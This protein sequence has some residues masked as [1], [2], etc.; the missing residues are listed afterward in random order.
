MIPLRDNIPNVH[1]PVMVTTLVIINAAVFLCGRF[2][3]PQGQVYVF[4]IFGVVPLRITDTAWAMAHGYPQGW[5]VPFFTHMFL[6]SSWMH[7]IGN[8]WTLWIFGDNIEDVM[9]PFRF[10]L[11]YL[12]CGFAAL[13]AHLLFNFSS[14]I[15]VVGASG[16]IAGVMG[17]YLILYP[18]AKVVTLIPIFIF[19]W[20][21]D[22]P[23][24]LFLGVWFVLQFFNGAATA[25]GGGVAWWAHVGGFVAG[26]VLLKV[27]ENPKR[28]QECYLAG[29]N[30]FPFWKD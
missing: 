19:P 17:A 10:L 2:L 21:V 7:I 11:F 23:A 5:L 20:F 14:P 1:K 25:G 18:Y 4:H 24:V 26:I 3:T 27:F 6:H 13:C 15:P 12:G 22:L 28:C 29:K 8:M 30:T 16:A 9:G